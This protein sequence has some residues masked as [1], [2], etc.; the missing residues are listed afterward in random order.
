MGTFIIGRAGPAGAAGADGDDGPQGPQGDP[1]ADGVS[2]YDWASP[3][4]EAAGDLLSAVATGDFTDIASYGGATSVYKAACCDSEAVRMRTD[5]QSDGST[6]AS[7]N[8]A[9]GLVRSV[10]SGDFVIGVRFSL[11]RV[12]QRADASS[13]VVLG[14]PVFVDGTDA[15]A[16]SWYGAMLYYSGSGEM[17]PALYQVQNESG[18]SRFETYDGSYALLGTL[19]NLVGAFDGI[20]ERSGTSLKLHLCTARGQPMQVGSWTVST[21]AGLMGLRIQHAGGTGDNLQGN[22]RAY[23]KSLTAVPGY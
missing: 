11:F 19:Y 9:Q 22:I 23:R 5:L 17:A 7:G 1:G 15:S 4:Y 16:D 3:E 13:S 14:G 8:R 18:S 20:Y 6:A 21:G 12:G 10:A 2:G